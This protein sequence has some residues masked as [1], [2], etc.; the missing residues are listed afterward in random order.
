LEPSAS[1]CTSE[2]KMKIREIILRFLYETEVD[3]C[4]FIM[5]K[6]NF[7]IFALTRI[8][9]QSCGCGW[10]QIVHE[11]KERRKLPFPYHQI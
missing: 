5:V 4:L 7:K 8:Y 6:V 10:N 11:K 3:L 9:L 1:A 2:N